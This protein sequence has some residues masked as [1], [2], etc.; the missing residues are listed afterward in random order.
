MTNFALFTRALLWAVLAITPACAWSEA[1][2]TLVFQVRQMT[3]GRSAEEARTRTRDLAFTAAL[4]MALEQAAVLSADEAE[5]A[6]PDAALDASV[7]AAAT[8]CERVQTALC[9]WARLEEESAFV[10]ALERVEVDP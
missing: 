2:P 5:I 6:T 8:S 9:T 10:A 4:S 7:D 1:Q 3:R